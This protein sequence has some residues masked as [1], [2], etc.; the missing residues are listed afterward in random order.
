MA[1]TRFGFIVT[2][3]DF[4][5]WTGTEHFRM[6]VVGVKSPEQ[7]IQAAREMVTEGSS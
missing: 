5:Q 3:D 7:G 4:V 6:K 1:L 2:G